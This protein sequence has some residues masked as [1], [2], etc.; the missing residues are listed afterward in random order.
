MLFGV[1]EETSDAAVYI[2][3]SESVIERLVTHSSEKEFWSDLIAFTSKDEN[4]TKAHVR[5][6]EARFCQLAVAANRYRVLNATQP[7]LPVLPRPDRDAMEE[8]IEHARTLLGV[9]GH[10]VLDPYVTP[11]RS[12][13]NE[14]PNMLELEVED[15]SIQ[16]SYVA[17][18]PI[19]S[20]RVNDLAT[21]AVRTD[22]GFVV[23]SGSEV[24][25]TTHTSLSASNRVLRD[26]LIASGT[27]V[28]DGSR[29]RLLKDQ[30][31]NSSSQA[32]GFI[33]GYSISGP[34]EWRLSDG[35]RLSEYEAVKAH[36]VIKT[37]STDE[38]G[39]G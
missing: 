39:D 10:R 28:D 4:L 22:E 29:L 9:L 8:F 33:V 13:Q 20:L 17:N 14:S 21:Q 7:Q 11:P 26:K 23:L 19:F 38:S 27:L 32:A 31:F 16:P 37:L 3:E 6:L 15:T 35:T 25:R 18:S 34:S 5:Y 36:Q 24:N 2:G 30:L 1:T 12:I